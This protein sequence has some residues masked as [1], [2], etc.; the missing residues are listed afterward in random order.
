[1]ARRLTRHAPFSYRPGSSAFHRLPA[2]L[3][4]LGLIVFSYLSFASQI[5]LALFALLLAVSCAVTRISLGGL[6]KGSK[7][8]LMLALAIMLVKTVGPENPGLATPGFS[9]FG[10]GVPGLR[11]PAVSAEG[12]LEGAIVALRVFV[13]FAGAAFLFAVTT[14]RELRVSLAALEK[15]LAR[16]FFALRGKKAGGRGIQGAALF[17]LGISLMLGFIPRFFDIWE[18]ADLSLRARSSRRGLRRLSIIVPLV[19]EK[20]MEAAAETA[21]AL[22]ARG[23]MRGG[24][25]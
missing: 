6:L 19:T 3:K 7:P 1:M 15:R 4:L 23:F 2:G 8:L 16:I 24:R 12:F 5:G 11:I 25:N 10:F 22:E 21:L 13:V 14:M 9:L 18:T 20:M 17:S